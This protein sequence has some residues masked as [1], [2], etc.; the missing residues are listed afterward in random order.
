MKNKEH[1]AKE[2]HLGELVA[3]EYIE[4]NWVNWLLMNMLRDRH[5]GTTC[6]FLRA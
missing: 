1:Y 6:T 3:Y 5:G 4:G 2:E